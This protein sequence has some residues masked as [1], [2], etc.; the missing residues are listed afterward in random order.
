MSCTFFYMLHMLVSVG[1]AEPLKSTDP[2]VKRVEHLAYLRTYLPYLPTNLSTTCLPTYL[3][4]C[5]PIFVSSELS[6]F[7]FSFLLFYLSSEPPTPRWGGLP[8]PL[9]CVEMPP[10]TALEG[11]E[12]KRKVRMTNKESGCRNKQKAL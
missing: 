2:R 4:T 10:L 11:E 12:D 8:P 3:P 6:Y 5:I 1:R 9:P 7:A